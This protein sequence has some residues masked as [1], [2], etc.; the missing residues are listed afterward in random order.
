MEMELRF[1][2]SDIVTNEDGSMTVSG[3][4]NKTEEKSRM[5]GK[6]S[7]FVEVI[8]R[9]AWQRA[10]DSAKEVHFLAEH[11]NNKILASTR[12]G[13]L[14][15]VEDEVG[16]HMTATISPTSWGKD[17]YQLIKDGILNN[18]SFGFRSIKDAWRN[19][20]SYF[21]RTVNELELFEVSVVRD[22]AYLGS[23]IATRGIDL[24]ED[25][26]IPDEVR[27][28]NNKIDISFPTLE[29]RSEADIEKI[30]EALFNKIMQNAKIAEGHEED[31]EAHVQETVTV[32]DEPVK[33]TEEP[34]T[35][36]EETEVEE[37]VEEK[38]DEPEPED[39]NLVENT[40]LD[41]LRDFINKHKQEEK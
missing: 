20:G 16:L 9:G 34:E 24:I 17:Y 4:V 32:E 11:D 36:A 31:A 38:V 19:A 10:L 27:N 30:A 2:P 29:I 21:E 7:K 39:E 6:D 23:S 15:L 18:M 22:P 1:N 3:Y 12:N 13:S 5:L 14:K 35:V 40:G 26:E 25:V 37:V 41:K 28:E 8:K 33:E